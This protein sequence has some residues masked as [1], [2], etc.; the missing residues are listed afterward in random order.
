MMA[1]RIRFGTD[2]VRGRVG[3]DFGTDDI[4]RLGAVVA[5]E[6]PRHHVLIG[7]DGRE[8]GAML[9]S[10]FARGVQSRGGTVVNAGLV[11][12]PTLA[13]A[14]RHRN[15]VAASITAS[16]NPWQ[17]NGVKVFAPGGSKLSDETQRRIETLWHAAPSAGATTPRSDASA[18]PSVESSG[19]ESSGAE[20]TSV[21]GAVLEEY[22]G[23]LGK[24]LGVAPFGDVGIAVD[25]ANGAMSSVAG[26]ILA[27]LGVRADIVND[28]PDGRNIN[29]GCGATHPEALAARC[30]RLGVVGV[31]FDGDGDRLIAVDEKGNVVDGD[32]LIALAAIDLKQRNLL[33]N[34]TVVVTS[35]TNLGFHRAMKRHGITAVVTEVGDRAVL[36][37]MDDGGFVLGGEQSGHIIHARHATTGDGL[38]SAILLLDLVRRSKRTLDDL[39]RD[40]MT[41]VPQVLRNV[42]VAQR[43]DDVE[44][45]LSDLLTSERDALGDDGRIVVRVSGT[46]PLVRI[47]VEAHSQSVADDVATRLERAVIARA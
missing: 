10:A 26:R 19:A 38:L 47:M 9:L 33:A 43:P 21:D 36:A 27:A 23:A 14:A 13:F 11:P 20:S 3:T 22:V 29:E 39:A 5:A 40:V 42:R 24:T 2:G 35:M 6:W 7:H 46:E 37:A 1:D 45:L 16:H 12:T 18:R 4:E 28:E 8:S 41:R 32:R 25:C 30:A 34:D 31:A 17:D 15:C 44:S